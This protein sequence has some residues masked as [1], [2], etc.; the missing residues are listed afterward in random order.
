MKPELLPLADEDC[1]CLQVEVLIEE[2]WINQFLSKQELNIPVSEKYSL[3]HLRIEFGEGKLALQGEMLEKDGTI[4]TVICLPKWDAVQQ[5]IHL[6][7]LEI[8]TQSKNILVKSAGW[9]AKTFMGAKIDKKIEEAT[10][11]MYA[12][13]MQKLLADG[14][15]IPITNGGG[16]SVRVRS[17]VITEM[18]FH[19]YNIKVKAMIDGYWTL[20]LKAQPII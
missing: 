10:N 8:K 19:N 3:T 13:Q 12:K 16:A 11:E 15:T 17:M 2:A 18:T 6:E 5:R 1:S 7:E 4:I 14:L 9:F 20:Q